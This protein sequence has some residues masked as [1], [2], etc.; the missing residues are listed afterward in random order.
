MCRSLSVKELFLSALVC[1]TA[2]GCNKEK[3]AAKP[4]AAKQEI[5]IAWWDVKESKD[6]KKKDLAEVIVSAT[7]PAEK[8]CKPS[9]RN[10]GSYE[11][12][13]NDLKLVCADGTTLT[14]EGVNFGY[15]NMPDK[16]NQTE[17]YPG[18]LEG[19]AL[20]P[21]DSAKFLV[22]RKKLEAGGLKFQVRDEPPVLLT[23]EKRR[24][25]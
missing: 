18:S 3:P 4:A 8:L 20:K 21:Q 14:A 24:Q 15:L 19:N 11:W 9:A 1:L 13:Y 23:D 2:A 7:V 22:E 25:K 17:S 10:P 16:Y 5:V 6:S 12:K